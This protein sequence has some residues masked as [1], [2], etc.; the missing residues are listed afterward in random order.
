MWTA[1]SAAILGSSFIVVAA[2]YY[3]AAG[4]PD[5]AGAVLLVIAGLSMAFGFGVLIVSS[6]DL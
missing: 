4:H 6:R 2:I 3:L 1:R 5:P